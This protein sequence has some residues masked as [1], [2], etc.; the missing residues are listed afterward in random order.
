[1]LNVSDS[2]FRF[3]VDV[4]GLQVSEAADL[5]TRSDDPVLVPGHS[6]VIFSR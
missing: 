2:E 4:G 6:W 1:L 5:G 3:P